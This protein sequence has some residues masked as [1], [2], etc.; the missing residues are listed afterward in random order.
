MRRAALAAVCA[1]LLVSVGRAQKVFRSGIDLVHFGVTV[2]DRKGQL[3]TGLTR[4]DFEVREDATPQDIRFFASADD[5][6]AAAPLHLGL[7]FDTS[8]SMD[9]DIGFS[10]TAAIKF[11]NET[12]Q[13]VDITLVDFDTE[14]RVARY[15]QDDFPRIIERIRNQRP[16]GY[17]ALYDA[18]G[19]YLHG[20]QDLDGQKVLVV[21]TDGG[22]TR[23]S[24]SFG[25]C[26]SLLRMSDATV[27]AVGFLAHQPTGVR[28][29]QQMYLR[30]I[31]ATT[32]G[33]AYFPF[34]KD[35]LE[36]FYDKIH[37]ELSARYDLGYLSTNTKADGAWRA[38]EIRVVKPGLR[39]VKVRARPGYYGPYQPDGGR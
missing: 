10:R 12:S 31:A 32:G 4:A 25:D 33:E 36:K 21:Y 18:L 19:V 23:S 22:D 30:Q 7:L 3:V 27:Y 28:L 8:G 20:A 1:I 9:E 29:T 35:D 16:E 34:S 2:L 13:A 5:H 14:V 15:S 6:Q 24:M 26:M 11:L 38:V 17:T 37:E 39:G